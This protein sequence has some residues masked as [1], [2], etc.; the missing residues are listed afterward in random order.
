MVRK[1][2][3]ALG[4]YDS[5]QYIHD[6]SHEH[7]LMAVI[8]DILFGVVAVQCVFHFPHHVNKNR[9]IRIITCI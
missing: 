4:S 5:E 1:M 6:D 7:M 8:V 9:N 3:N 2:K